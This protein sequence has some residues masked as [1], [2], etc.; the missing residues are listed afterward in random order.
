MRDLFTQET[1]TVGQAMDLVQWQLGSNKV[2]I[3]Y[4]T[5]FKLAGQIRV[6]AKA[7]VALAGGN[8]ALW[9]DLAKY[10]LEKPLQP[11]HREYR[12][13]GHLSNLSH[14]PYVRVAGELV[15]VQLDK[16]QAKFH[17]TDAL[18][19]QAMILRAAREAKQWAGDGSR[20]VILS[21]HL[22]NATPDDTI[23]SAA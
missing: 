11:L 3:Y 21:A 4:P 16:L 12:R 9:R 13:S 23:R 10:E 7:A 18:I 19:V 15:V 5:A 20:A 1:V 22:T 14:E 17:C 6:C 8:A 2:R